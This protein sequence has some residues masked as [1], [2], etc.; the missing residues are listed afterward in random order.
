MATV[1]VGFHQ[2]NSNDVDALMLASANARV[3]DNG[4]GYPMDVLPSVM[5]G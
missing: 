3:G 5:R 2:S 1:A 4:Y